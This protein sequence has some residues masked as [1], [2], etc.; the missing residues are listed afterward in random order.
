MSKSAN[1]LNDLLEL[2]QLR[3][4]W[5]QLRNTHFGELCVAFLQVTVKDIILFIKIIAKN[6][7]IRI[8]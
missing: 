3:N 8:Q 1:V 7:C 6:M 4:K 2:Q 5:T